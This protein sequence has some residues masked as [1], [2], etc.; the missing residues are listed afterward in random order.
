MPPGRVAG[1]GPDADRVAIVYSTD[2]GVEAMGRPWTQ[3]PASSAQPRVPHLSLMC[4]SRRHQAR[5]WEAFPGHK[6]SPQE[7][8]EDFGVAG[9]L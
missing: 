7:G 6:P 8:W 3:A 2:E 5:I 4:T 1:S 9:F